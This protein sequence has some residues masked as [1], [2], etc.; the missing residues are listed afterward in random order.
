MRSEA[1]AKFVS[2][3]P[4]SSAS[5]FAELA[6]RPLIS[7]RLPSRQIDQRKCREPSRLRQRSMTGSIAAPSPAW[8]GARVA[9]LC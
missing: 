4:R 2:H 1:R 3:Q 7:T 5:A 8:V 9:A 6:S